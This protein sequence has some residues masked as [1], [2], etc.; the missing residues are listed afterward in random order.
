[1]TSCESDFDEVKK[2]IFMNLLPS[3]VVIT[4]Y[5]GGGSLAFVPTMSLRACTWVAT[6]F[7]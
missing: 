2:L 4:H 1:M 7:N 6:D 5:L 3:F